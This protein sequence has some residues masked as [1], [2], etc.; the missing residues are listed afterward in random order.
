[1]SDKIT[2]PDF[3]AQ[4]G[5]VAPETPPGGEQSTGQQFV[6]VEEAKRL[7][8]AAAEQ[9]FRRAQGLVDKASQA[10]QLKVREA[11]S[12][13]DDVLKMQRDSGI[14][15][16]PEQEAA[17]RS[18]VMEKAYTTDGDKPLSQAGETLP[19]QDAVPPPDPITAEAWRRMQANGVIIEETDPEIKLL[20]G[21]TSPQD[22]LAK[23]DQAIIA[24]KVR[25]QPATQPSGVDISLTPTSAGGSG[26]YNPNDLSQVK[27]PDALWELASKKF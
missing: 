9:A 6:T 3:Q 1:M 20:E 26:R 12:K 8:E 13:V 22:W 16:T 7:A 2:A 21:S 24:K 11:L 25:T 10:N 19:D 15:I 4:P 5:Q 14:Q 17:L 27:D 18:R 23:I